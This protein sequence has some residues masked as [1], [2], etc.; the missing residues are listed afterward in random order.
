MEK[1]SLWNST[2]TVVSKVLRGASVWCFVVPPLTERTQFSTECYNVI[3]P[4]YSYIQLWNIQHKG[5]SHS[6][7]AAKNMNI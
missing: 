4:F 5:I 6:R 2:A 7:Q 3:Q 1:H